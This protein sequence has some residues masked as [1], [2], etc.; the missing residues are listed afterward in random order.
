MLRGCR[1]TATL[2]APIGTV[3][4]TLR[5]WSIAFGLKRLFTHAHAV[6][7]WPVTLAFLAVLGVV[8]TCALA[9]TRIGPYLP[10]VI[11]ARRVALATVLA[12]IPAIA[13]ASLHPDAGMLANLTRVTQTGA[14]SL[15]GVLGNR[16]RVGRAGRRALARV[17]AYIPGIERTGD[18]SHVRFFPVLVSH[19]SHPRQAFL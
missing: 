2:G 6:D 3:E 11:L 5:T 17:R 16:A 18:E 1:V 7:W 10:R 19:T 8:L 9:L 15:A 14:V 12:N 13:L 4:Q